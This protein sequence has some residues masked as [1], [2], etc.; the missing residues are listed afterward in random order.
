MICKY[1]KDACTYNQRHI[2]YS[3]SVFKLMLK[4][5]KYNVEKLT[6]HKCK[7]VHANNLEFFK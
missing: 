2:T 3:Y 6:C 7:H 4:Q 1:F 5:N